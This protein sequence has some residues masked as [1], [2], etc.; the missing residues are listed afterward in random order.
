MLR[1][2]SATTS[3]QT[4]HNSLR[5]VGQCGS[6]AVDSQ[7]EGGKWS[8]ESLQNLPPRLASMLSLRTPCTLPLDLPLG[9]QIFKLDEARSAVLKGASP[10]K[11]CL[12]PESYTHWNT[13]FQQFFIICHSNFGLKVCRWD[14]RLALCLANCSPAKCFVHADKCCCS[15]R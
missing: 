13:D 3:L 8:I 10:W 14:K 9:N 15:V 6:G 11:G 12:F 7:G 2:E 1:D 5:L 4:S